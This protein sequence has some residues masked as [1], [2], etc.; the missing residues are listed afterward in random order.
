MRPLLEE[1]LVPAYRALDWLVSAY[2]QGSL[3]EG[4][5][6]DADLDLVLVWREEVPRG[7]SRPPAGLAD[8]SP[9]TSVYGQVGFVLDRFWLSGQQI[10][11][12]HVTVAEVESWAAAVEAGGGT[13]GYP[14]PVVSVYGLVNGVILA[15][16]SKYLDVMRR[17]LAVVPGPL[18]QASLAA[19]RDASYLSELEACAR[20]GDTL[21]FH[22]LLVEYLR[23][24]FIAWF[25]MNGRYWPHEKRLGDRLRLAGRDDLALLEQSVWLEGRDLSQR[26]DGVRQLAA[27]LLRELEPAG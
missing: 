15:D 13:H 24:L 9:P 7:A 10:D 2:A 18:R 22:S 3:V 8:A 1:R 19:A 4:L 26:L 16:D 23:A 14:M 20:R 6:E 25:A 11:A 27:V 21:L 12:K 5:S 17:R